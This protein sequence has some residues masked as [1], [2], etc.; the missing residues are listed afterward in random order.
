M[1]KWLALVT[2]AIL[3]ATVLTL[4]LDRRPTAIVRAPLNPEEVQPG[5]GP[6]DFAAELGAA[7]LSLQQWQARLDRDPGDWLH[8]E[9]VALSLAARFRLNGDY[10]DLADADRLL[11]EAMAIPPWPAGPVMSR[12]AISL[13][14]HRLDEAEAALKRFEASAVPP[15]PDEREAVASL[16]CEIALQR[17]L[18]R[19]AGKI[20]GTSED[21]G[22]RMR[23]ANI[24]AKMGRF[25]EAE[26]VLEDL[27][28]PPR[29]S[30]HR[31]A[32]LCLQRASVALARGDLKAAGIWSRA[33]DRMFAGYW[34]AEAFVAQ[35]FALE[36]KLDEASRRY[37]D[38]VETTG[39]PDVIDAYATVLLANGR[40]A[41]ARLWIARSRRAWE[42]RMRLLPQAAATHF[43]EHL[44][45]FGDARA[46]LDQAAREFQR[47]PTSTSAA[48]YAAILVALGDPEKGLKVLMETESRGWNT[49]RMKFEAAGAL[50]A[51]GRRQDAAVAL[52]S[53]QALNP[54]VADLRQRFISFDQD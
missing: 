43:A 46:A 8:L 27:L 20:C 9:G 4:C 54:L 34:L 15:G 31:L 51:L 30:P 26:R 35:Q 17:G 13:T 52:K 2:L 37:R 29:Q 18:P 33:A 32:V 25:D 49:A 39:N 7:E 23:Q 12:A 53:A 10:A 38:L 48:N 22:L 21:P 45:E 1:R 6:R 44:F 5:P 19:A 28:R 24:A 47:R 50:K 3:A 36:G 16:R 40:K 42:E 11:D 41:E 14:V